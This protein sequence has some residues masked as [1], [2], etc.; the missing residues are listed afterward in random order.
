MKSPSS[1]PAFWGARA[2]EYDEYIRRV[3][4][5]YEVLVARLL[6][7]M[8]ASPRR[9]VELGCGTG[10]LSL[11]L[12]RRFPDASLTLVDAAPEMIE[13]ARERVSERGTDTAARVRYIVARFEELQLEPASC[14]SIVASLSL[15]HVRELAPV[16]DIL[17]SALSGGGSLRIADGY[18]GATP[19]LHARH[20]ERWEA[21]WREA[22]NLTEDEI[23]TVTQHVREHDYYLPVTE[24]FR[25][26]AAVGFV[27]CDCIWRD[28]L[29]AVVGADVVS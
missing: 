21:Y 23:T 28:G 13:I 20:M 8:P 12:L 16:Y 29:F 24:H 22:G 9:I 4:P 15:H 26:L 3:V 2:A 25:M 14:D 27:A 7:Y 11:A 19:A 17:S 6:D 5:H 1:A 18:A 10:A